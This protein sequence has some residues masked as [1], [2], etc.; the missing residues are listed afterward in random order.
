[1][2]LATR[3]RKLAVVKQRGVIFS[4]VARNLVVVWLSRSVLSSSASLP[5]FDLDPGG[6]R[7]LLQFLA[8]YLGLKQ[9]EEGKEVALVWFSFFNWR[10]YDPPEVPIRYYFISHWSVPGH[11]MS[12]G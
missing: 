9:K 5:F 7:W 4:H 8:S 3:N 1:M 12:S 11:L 10:A 6:M 2:L